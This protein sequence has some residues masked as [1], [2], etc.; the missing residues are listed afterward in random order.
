MSNIEADEVA[1][2]AREKLLDAVM[3]HVHG[4][5]LG[6]ESL[7]QLAAAVGSSHRMLIYHFESRRGLS[8]AVAA[9]WLAEHLR[10]MEDRK[11]D[12][13]A[14][15]HSSGGHSSAGSRMPDPHWADL[16]ED[17]EVQGALLFE[18]WVRAMTDG[19]GPGDPRAEVG[20]ARAVSG[21]W[22]AA[23]CS[24]ELAEV[25]AVLQ[26]ATSRG[27]LLDL[28]L[29]GDK[30][31]LGRCADRLESVLTSEGSIAAMEQLLPMLGE[32]GRAAGSQRSRDR[33]EPPTGHEP[34]TEG[35]SA[36]DQLLDALMVCVTTSGLGG[37]SLRQLAAAL[38]TSH[39][40]LIY[41]FGSR[42]GLIDEV[43]SR[44]QAEQQADLALLVD[45][46]RGRPPNGEVFTAFFGRVLDRLDANGPL[47]F[48]LALLAI[49]R[50]YDRPRI[51][52]MVIDGFLVPVAD[53]WHS[54]GFADSAATELARLNIAISYGLMIDYLLGGNRESFFRA[55]VLFGAMVGRAVGNPEAEQ[56]Q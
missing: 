8:E 4:H 33:A 21:G 27:L 41:H 56:R 47:I 3:T 55:L 22:S 54:F 51:R 6:G 19:S 17:L 46:E 20:V 1:Q 39:R 14:G 25:L 15:G 53:F 37:R 5:G 2:P 49:Q 50:R 10:Q 23:G 18:L 26:L 31:E 42:A 29:G 48:E 36:R 44:M 16:V 40:M 32:V 9:R 30:V 28:L 38:G 34:I 7:R 12:A 13:T 52:T 24:P 11:I 45:G 35:I 43:V